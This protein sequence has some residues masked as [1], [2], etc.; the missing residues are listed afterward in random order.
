MHGMHGRERVRCGR[1]SWRVAAGRIVRSNHDGR[2]RPVCARGGAKAL[3]R[4]T[5][6]KRTGAT[7]APPNLA[8][9]LYSLMSRFLHTFLYP[10]LIAYK[11]LHEAKP[12]RAAREMEINQKD[13]RL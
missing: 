10:P 3:R 5:G 4:L 11:E 9:S 7:S 2:G 6:R 12:V 13:T 1:S 8:I